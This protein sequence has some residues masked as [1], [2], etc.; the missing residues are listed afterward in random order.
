MVRRGRSRPAH[1]AHA[2]PALGPGAGCRRSSPLRR[3]RQPRRRFLREPDEAGLAV[4]STPGTGIR[5]S[6]PARRPTR[7]STC[8]SGRRQRLPV[9][10]M[11][12]PRVGL[13]GADVSRCRPCLHR[14]AHD[15][16]ALERYQTLRVALSEG[17]VG[18]MPFLLER[19]DE[20][21][22]GAARLRR[23][24]APATHRRAATSPDGSTAASSTT[25]SDSPCVTG[26]A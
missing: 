23:G 20:H 13:P 12:A 17:Q 25:R 21:M 2:H 5:S 10:S 26:S 11:D 3:Q 15:V 14:L 4:A 24:R 19:L 8:T 7:S 16:G 18:W 1:P 9:T 22:G 6:R